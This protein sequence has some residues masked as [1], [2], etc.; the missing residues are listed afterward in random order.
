MLAIGRALLANPRVLLFDEPSEGL[1]PLLVDRMT[2]T[3]AGLRERGLS[4]IVIEQN[5]HVAVAL[6]DRVAIMTKGEIVYRA[7]D[8]R[9]PREPRDRARPAR[10]LVSV[11]S[12]ELSSEPVGEAH[13]V[14]RARRVHDPD[15]RSQRRSRPVGRR[16]ERSDEAGTPDPR[17]RMSP[18]GTRLTPPFRADHV[19][20]LLR[21]PEL[22][23]RAT[24]CSR[25]ARRRRLR[26]VE[27]EAFA[28]PS[29]MQRDV[30][31]Q[32]ATDGEF[33]RTSWH[34]DFIYRLGGVTPAGGDDRR[35]LPR[36]RGRHRPFTPGCTSTASS[37][38]TSR[39]S[40]TTSPSSAT[41]SRR[42]SPKLTIPRRA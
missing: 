40:A 20:S 25:R 30:G 36:R 35:P 18:P 12:T 14:A 3:I 11:G 41:R 34:M 19:G 4:A 8:G 42:P 31:L 10:R 22:L 9:V 24:P 28:P 23:R 21:P 1:A 6:A 2:E 26:A 16:K 13:R 33:R 27:D 32:S 15:A 38:S 17:N 5:L 37:G 29:S 39:S 7:D